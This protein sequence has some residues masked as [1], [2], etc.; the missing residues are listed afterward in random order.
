LTQLAFVYLLLALSRTS[1]LAVI[2]ISKLKSLLSRSKPLLTKLS[3]LVERFKVSGRNLAVS[4]ALV[5]SLK[6]FSLF[7]K[8]KSLTMLLLTKL[9]SK[10][11][12][13]KTSL[14]SSNFKNSWKHILEKKKKSL[15]QFTTQI[16][17]T[18]RPHSKE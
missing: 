13:L 9:K 18:W 10:L 5:P 4:L 3:L 12:S 7:Q 1:K 16:K 17:T 15:K 2:F 6:L 14:S 8:L 11:T